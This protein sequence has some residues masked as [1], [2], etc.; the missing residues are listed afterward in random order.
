M[1][2]PGTGGTGDVEET[3]TRIEYYHQISQR[4]GK[5]VHSLHPDGQQGAL[6]HSCRPAEW[7][8]VRS[9][10]SRYSHVEIREGWF[11][12]TGEARESE[13]TN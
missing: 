4:P 2:H 10:D 5:N 3:V 12:L 9:S 13:I 8:L 6:A 11:A 1:G 7:A